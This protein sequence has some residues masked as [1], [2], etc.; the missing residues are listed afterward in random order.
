MGMRG[1]AAG[2]MAREKAEEPKR[3]GPA[4][5]KTM[6]RDAGAYGAPLAGTLR[7]AQRDVNRRIAALT[8]VATKGVA[9]A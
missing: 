9:G 6:V 4:V 8:G 2:A 5:T 1:V 3:A 7:Q